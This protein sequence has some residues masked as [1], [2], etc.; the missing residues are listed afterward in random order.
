MNIFKVQIFFQGSNLFQD[1]VACITLICSVHER[2]LLNK[3][4]GKRMKSTM[5]KTHLQFDKNTKNIHQQ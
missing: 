5:V 1:F 4:R 3:K 2:C